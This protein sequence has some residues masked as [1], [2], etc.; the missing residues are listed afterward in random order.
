[1][2][3][4]FVNLPATGE[5][6]RVVELDRRARVLRS[7]WRTASMASG[8]RF[9]GDWALPEV[10]TVC[11]AA[12]AQDG[13][14]IAG[15]ETALT[16]LARGRADAGSGLGET[17]TDVAALHAVFEHPDQ[18]DGF[19]A[20][21]VDAMPSRLVRLVAL[22]WSETALGKVSRTEVTDSLT[23]LATLPY[24]RTRLAELY[25]GADTEMVPRDH[26]LL[27]VRMDF[28]E[29]NG[30]CRLV[31][32]IIAADVL[33]HTFRNGESLAATGPSTV[34]ALVSR[35]AELR[36]RTLELRARLTRR[37]ESDLHL[38]GLGEPDIRLHALPGNHEAACLQLERLARD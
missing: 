9:P 10:D 3:R 36:A 1:M 38:V 19:V 12:R 34:A 28:A 4:C 30:W 15:L 31:G 33:H 32:M 18:A 26:G 24:L 6:A 7:R 21:D 17:L 29:G 5:S 20:P 37:L 16:A 22:A 13:D 2:R 35:D 27:L 23:G 25:R 14:G 8:W 11:A